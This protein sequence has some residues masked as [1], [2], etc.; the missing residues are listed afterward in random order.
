MEKTI[1]KRIA[2]IVILLLAVLVPSSA[3]M[4]FS[5]YDR[6]I[7]DGQEENQDI[8]LINDT[9]IV[10]EGGTVNGDVTLFDSTAD[11]AGEING[12]VSVFNSEVVL[13]GRISGDLVL[14]AGSLDVQEEASIDGSCF[15]FGG[16]VTDN[17]DS[18]SCGRVE[19]RFDPSGVLDSIS[20]PAF[21]GR[22][23]API[24][25]ERPE[26]QPPYHQPPAP[27]GPVER[28]ASRIGYVVLSISEVVGRSLL[29]GVLA[30]LISAIFPRQ[31]SQVSEAVRRKPAASG[32]VGLLTAIAGPSLIV[33]LLVVLAITC[34]GLLLYPAVFMLGLALIAA[35]L[36][37]WVAL[38]DVFGRIVANALRMRTTGSAVTALGT[39]LLTMILGG[40]G[41]LPFIWGEGVL[42][43]LLACV[44][45]GAAALTQLGTR[46]Y[47][48]DGPSVDAPPAHKIYE[49]AKGS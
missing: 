41:I 25:P 11:I 1:M 16:E 32:V 7:R 20:P 24:P 43:A 48:P 33:L 39:T 3:A 26:F 35:A 42:V 8:T 14:F 37:G 46:P 36:L 34:V 12:R 29:M 28:A 31:V 44:G 27:R 23:E 19:S 21:P 5:P 2:I 17:N 15:V 49:P 13:T 22:P 18:I 9:L 47:P 4:A 38:G 40:L 6:I 10:E 45:L 30:L